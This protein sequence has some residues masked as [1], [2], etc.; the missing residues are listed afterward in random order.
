MTPYFFDVVTYSSVRY[1][2]SGTVLTSAEQ[3]FEWAEVLAIDI[4]CSD[5]V[6]NTSNVEVRDVSG[7]L[8]HSV[9]VRPPELS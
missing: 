5:E 6:W 2:Y 9:K 8:L 7:N 3:A 1:D 4:E